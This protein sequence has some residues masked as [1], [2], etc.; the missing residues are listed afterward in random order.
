MDTCWVIT[1]EPQRK[2]SKVQFWPGRSDS[3]GRSSVLFGGVASCTGSALS[4]DVHVGR[5]NKRKRKKGWILARA[6]KVSLGASSSAPSSTREL[7]APGMCSPSLP[8]SQERRK[9]KGDTELEEVLGSMC[10]QA[11]QMQ[12]AVCL[13][14]AHSPGECLGLPSPP[15][16]GMV[17]SPHPAPCWDSSCCSSDLEIR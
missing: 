9:I 16:S 11:L 10:G 1:T 8:A 15:A 4:K 12:G 3:P 6:S 5:N 7:R 2:L 14:L 17:S 13:E